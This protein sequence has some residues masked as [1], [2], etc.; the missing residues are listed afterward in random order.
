MKHPNVIDELNREIERSGSEWHT[1]AVTALPQ[2]W[3]NVMDYRRVPADVD[4]EAWP[5]ELRCVDYEPCPALL[6]QVQP[7]E[8]H[9]QRI[10][11]ARIDHRGHL[12][13]VDGRFYVATVT[14][15]EWERR[16]A[17]GW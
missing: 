3:L 17:A 12:V 14:A 9:D 7:G 13:P 11:A 15:E 2:G 8:R 10:V 4:A 5:E 16:Q 6:T 1:I